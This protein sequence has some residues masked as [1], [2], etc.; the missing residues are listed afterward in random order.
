MSASTEISSV[1]I[2]QV[3]VIVKLFI[4]SFLSLTAGSH[5]R[6][7]T[8]D[9]RDDDTHDHFENAKHNS[10]ESVSSRCEYRFG[11]HNYV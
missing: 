5:V 9:W 7:D 10:V 2:I 8:A 3:D 6:D 4:D 1:S 11:L